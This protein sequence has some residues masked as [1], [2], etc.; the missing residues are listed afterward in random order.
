VVSGKIPEI[1]KILGKNLK[2]KQ[3]FLEQRFASGSSLWYNM[4]KGGACVGPKNHQE[5][6]WF[7]PA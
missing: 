6:T 1:Y 7:P 2:P 3:M 5:K 4:G